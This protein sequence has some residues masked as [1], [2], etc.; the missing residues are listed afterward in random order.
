MS[1]KGTRHD[2]KTEKKESKRILG[3]HKRLSEYGKYLPLA[4]I[5]LAIVTSAF[6]SIYF[7]MQPQYL[8]AT[9]D[10]AEN[11]INNMIRNNIA[12]GI[13]ARYPNIPPEE[14]EKII[15]QELLK[16]QQL[17]KISYQG[18]EILIDDLVEDQSQAFKQAFKD[19]DGSTYLLA[20]DPYYYYRLTENYV[21]NGYDSETEKDGEYYDTKNLAGLPVEKRFGTD[22]K[23]SNL[24]ILVSSYTHKVMKIFNPNISL[25][26]SFFYVPIIIATLC[27]IPAFFIG[28]KI[29]GNYGG[30]FASLLL[31]VHPAFMN[32]T[33]GGFSDTDAYNLLFPLV[34]WWFILEA[35]DAK[36]LKKASI[37]SAAL[38]VCIGLFSF[39]WNAWQFIF[40]FIMV[41]MLG[42]IGK[43]L[44]S[45]IVQH[46]GKWFQQAKKS[47]EL[48]NG[49]AISGITIL[50]TGLSVAAFSGVN[51][52]VKFFTA[53]IQFTQLK[54]VGVTKI[55]P[56]VFTTVAELNPASLSQTLSQ[57]SM[58]SKILLFLSI[59]GIF[60]PLISNK[61][62]ILKDKAFPLVGFGIWFLILAS[63]YKSIS[64]A[65]LFGATVSSNMFFAILLVVPI[66][67]YM[68]WSVVVNSENIAIQYSLMTL[69]WFA[70]TIYASSK[71][72][73]FVIL[74]VPAF[75][76]GVG[77]AVGIIYRSVSEWVSK[78]LSIDR[79][80]T[81]LAVAALLLILLFAPVNVFAKTWEQ[82]KHEVP[83]MNDQWYATLTKIKE[84]SAPNAIINSWWDFGHW[85]AAVGDR[86]VTLDGGRQNNPQAHWLGKL[87]LTWDEKESV[88]ILRY[89]DCGANTGFNALDS[90]NKDQLKSINEI[91]STL[92]LESREEAKTKLESAGIPTNV[93]ENV[94]QYTHCEAPENYFITSEDMVG[95]SAV[96]AHF[97]SWDFEKAS[98][99]N[100]VI[101]KTQGE[102]VDI[103]TSGFG[104]T[105]DE[106]E[107]LYQEI[108]AANAD[109]WIAP[110]PGYAGGSSCRVMNTTQLICGNGLVFNY[111][112]GEAQIMTQ[113]GS[114]KPKSLAYI[115]EDNE[116]T[117]KEFNGSVAKL[118]NG[119]EIGAAIIPTE[120]G[121]G[122]VFM[123]SA[124]TASMFT[125]LFYYENVDGGLEHFEKFY[126]TRDIT[127]QKIIVWKI[128]WEGTS[129]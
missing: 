30:F 97:G 23:V 18:K 111:E 35:I 17:G 43:T 44:L 98:M 104:K 1:K 82:A 62:K 3:G 118:N 61:G 81:K 22:K 63:S 49:L 45:L 67:V 101:G 129:Q 84:E 74:L 14:R 56:N 39:A 102:G 113:G 15:S 87:M 29:A 79:L 51:S 66:A 20:I 11:S 37:W 119:R 46:K 88:G 55:W 108:Q 121:L 34:A 94:T 122:A 116:F 123:D 124:L 78:N 58:G 83:S 54:L 8:P 77:V 19:K 99:F 112:T 53:L 103:L 120:N 59:L 93:A 65:N 52:I 114:L 128:N 73:R 85:F 10:W 28:R 42:Y 5:I 60:L 110:W 32:R 40:A 127:G 71:G 89:L 31:A 126:E 21:E 7:R 106:A 57:V 115:N 109:Q 91:Y 36:D 25:M 12:S 41:L 4:I 76:I 90:Y 13:N 16:T 125:R 105:P 70:A 2:N 95:K 100:K 86:A 64:G 68:L 33:A 47:D 96:W 27:V 6:F 38:A 75:S 69:I 80:A 9:D 50:G 48:K 26:G 107:K 24:H 72:I 117:V 92:T